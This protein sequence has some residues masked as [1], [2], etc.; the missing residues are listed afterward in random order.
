MK[1]RYSQRGL[2]SIGWLM[3]ILLAGFFLTLAFKMVPA[4]VD[5]IY[6]TDALKSLRE[7]GA[8]QQGYAGVTDSEVRRHLSGYFNINNVRADAVKSLKVERKSDRILVNMNYEVREPLFYNVDV[9]MRFTNQFDSTR[10]DE[11]CK[12]QDGA[13]P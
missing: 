4:Y 9:V 10:P 5:N 8:G 1:T 3:V 2:S 11:C 7:L 6:V 12:P 13:A